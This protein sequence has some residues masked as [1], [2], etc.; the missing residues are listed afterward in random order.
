LIRHAKSD[1][2]APAASDFE[3]PLNARGQRDG[4]RMARWLS[5][6]VHPAPWIWSSDAERAR[7]TAD[8]V[9]DGF[10]A[11]QARVVEAHELYDAAPETILEVIRSSPADTAS[12]AVVA[13]NPG[14]TQVLNLLVGRIVTENLP[15]FGVARLDVPA[16]WQDLAFGRAELDLLTSP[17]GLG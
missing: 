10:A 1:W 9:A 13:H 17:K 2:H 16:L 3:R 11:V 12:V 6:E 8:F 5:Q 15:T 4:P 7:R 14:M